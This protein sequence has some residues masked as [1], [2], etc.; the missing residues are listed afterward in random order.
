M[1]GTHMYE[2]QKSYKFYL[3][4]LEPKSRTGDKNP[5]TFTV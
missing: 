5:Y 2:A 4:A 1:Y 3:G